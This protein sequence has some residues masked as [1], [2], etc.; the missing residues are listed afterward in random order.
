MTS[1]YHLEK[2]WW[3]SEVPTSLQHILK[4]MWV[5]AQSFTSGSIISGAPSGNGSLCICFKEQIISFILVNWLSYPCQTLARH[6]EHI[7]APAQDPLWTSSVSGSCPFFFVFWLTDQFSLNWSFLS[8][9]LQ[10]NLHALYT[11]TRL[12]TLLRPSP[13]FCNCL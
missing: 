1:T 8:I 6:W 12:A 13:Y 10:P 3:P 5:L 11:Y 9:N 2:A 4:K 7:T